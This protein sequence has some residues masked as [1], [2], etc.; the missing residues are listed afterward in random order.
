M[1]MIE[2]DRL[3]EIIS[4]YTYD[5]DVLQLIDLDGW[6]LEDLQEALSILDNEIVERCNTELDEIS[7]D[8]AEDIWHEFHHG[9][10]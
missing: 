5:G 6:D 3:S 8:Y 2:T 4:K 9:K 1:T 10:D 7:D